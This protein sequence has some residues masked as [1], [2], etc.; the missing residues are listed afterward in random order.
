MDTTDR[1]PK[2]DPFPAWLPWLVAIGWT[3]AY[4]GTMFWLSKPDFSAMKPSEW[5]DFA[6]GWAAP[7]AFFFLIFDLRMQRQ[8]L[9]NNTVQL[10]NQVKELE[11]SV[12]AQ[13]QMAEAAKD[14][15]RMSR[16]QHQRS[17]DEQNRHF[18]PVFSVQAPKPD[19]DASGKSKRVIRLTLSKNSVTNF[20]IGVV[21]LDK[22]QVVKLKEI[23]SADSPTRMH[24]DIT[25]FAQSDGPI[26]L[27]LLAEFDLENGSSSF[28][29]FDLSVRAVYNA[30]G[31]KIKHRSAAVIDHGALVWGEQDA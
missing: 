25:R 24:L 2:K 9:Q 5:G 6:A 10:A 27:L 14:A 12:D 15:N 13:T 17:H 3:V 29:F 18:K 22:R 26:Q 11:N 7:L 28:S 21:D 20:R 4:L 16:E 8:E 19:A 30:P 31:A 23:E 1:K